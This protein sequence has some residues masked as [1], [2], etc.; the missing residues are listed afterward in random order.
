MGVGK[1]AENV[2]QDQEILTS[3]YGPGIGA[4]EA[5]P[6]EEEIALEKK[7]LRKIDLLIM[8][9]IVVIYLMNFIDR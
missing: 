1:S 7:L 9:L 6:S 3:K 2:I 8:P 5:K 4:V